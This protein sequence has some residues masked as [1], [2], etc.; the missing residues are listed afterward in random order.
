ML[1]MQLTHLKDQLGFL[2]NQSNQL[3]SRRQEDAESALY[4]G[5]ASLELALE[6]ELTRPDI[7]KHACTRLIDAVRLNH[8]DERPCL[9]LAFLF[10][11][12]EDTETAQ[13]YLHV[14][15]QIDYE[16]PLALALEAMLKEMRSEGPAAPPEPT[17]L[18]R[19]PQ[20]AQE[21]DYD[22]LYDQLEA[23]INAQ[24]AWLVSQPPPEASLQQGRIQLY[25]KLVHSLGEQHQAIQT[26]MAIVDQEIETGDLVQRLRPLEQRLQRYR[27]V[28]QQS[29]TL[30]RL[31]LDISAEIARVQAQIKRPTPDFGMDELF[32]RCDAF[33]DQLDVC[34]Q[35]G[36]PIALVT[37]AYT[38]LT[39]LAEQ[40]QEIL[41]EK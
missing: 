29:Q 13:E 26:Q 7:L 37:D 1:L 3:S 36:M 2:K 5:L 31:H 41:D 25:E 14:A 24:I 40:L 20:D 27:L 28:L 12:I 21:L 35:Q 38:R 32:D 39:T 33:A 18:N 15:R 30:E 8:R 6:H 22:Q 34:E 17:V 11:A 16:N 23:Q 4:E 19:V 9:A 10:L